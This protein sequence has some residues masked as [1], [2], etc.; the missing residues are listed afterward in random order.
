MKRIILM[1]TLVTLLAPIAFAAEIEGFCVIRVNNIQI[2]GILRSIR[3]TRN[4]QQDDSEKVK[5]IFF[6]TVINLIINK[7]MNI[8]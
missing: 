6:H 4:H 2:F 7:L 5:N 1:C 3:I 8:L